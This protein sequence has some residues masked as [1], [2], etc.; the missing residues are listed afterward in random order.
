MSEE[1]AFTSLLTMVVAVASLFFADG[2]VVNGGGNWTAFLLWSAIV[3]LIGVTACWWLHGA[4]WKKKAESAESELKDA[5]ADLEFAQANAENAMTALGQVLGEVE[6]RR[7]MLNAI[8]M[9]N[10]DEALAF[11]SARLDE[12][13]DKYGPA[14]S[15]LVKYG[16]VDGLSCT[17]MAG[18]NYHLVATDDYKVTRETYPS[19][20]E[21]NAIDLDLRLEQ[22]EDSAVEK[23][24]CHIERARAMY[25]TRR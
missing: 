8:A 24:L 20:S 7:N 14:L 1:A 25:P 18:G 22:V 16:C 21:R 17:L 3:F 15:D 9:M 6:L 5:K 2:W 23:I 11:M 4:K 13:G 12:D 10:E 19:L